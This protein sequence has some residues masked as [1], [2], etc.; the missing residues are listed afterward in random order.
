MR[1]RGADAGGPRK[2]SVAVAILCATTAVLVGLELRSRSSLTD[3]VAR[4]LPAPRD[5]EPR[6]A[7][8]R[9]PALESADLEKA[10]RASIRIRQALAGERSADALRASALL[11]LEPGFGQPA[12]ARAILR[13]EEAVGLDPDDASLWNDLAVAHMR[14]AKASDSP[15]DDL[16]ALELTQQA[17]R[18]DSLNPETRFNYALILERVFLLARAHDAFQ[19]V[20]RE[21]NSR[22]LREF[23]RT[24]LHFID[25]VRATPQWNLDEASLAA[26]SDSALR[27]LVHAVPQSAR[28]NL[29]GKLLPGW[30]ELTLQSGAAGAR[31]EL[32]IAQQ[33]AAHI[34]ER[35]TDHTF[36]EL[37]EAAARPQ[38][39]DSLR[40]LARGVLDYAEGRRLYVKALF[41]QA[42][43]FLSRAERELAAQ[44][45]AL[46]RLAGLEGAGVHMYA[47]RYE[48]AETILGNA[49]REVDPARFPVLVARA[50]YL[51]GLSQSR[52]GEQQSAIQEFQAAAALYSKLGERTNAALST[53][54]SAELLARLGYEEEAL[55]TWLRQLGELQRGGATTGLHDS[56]V[57]LGR[58]IGQ[59][60]LREAAITVHSEGLAVASQTGRPKD[61][62]EALLELARAELALNRTDSAALHIGLAR[63]HF[64]E[65][66]DP[67]MRDRAEANLAAAEGHL[68][69]S[70][71]PG[72][73]VTSL[74]TAVDHFRRQRNVINLARTLTLR[75]N[76]FENGGNLQRASVDLDSAI[77]VVVAEGISLKD[78][79]LRHSLLEAST[80]TFDN[81]IRI[82]VGRGR[83]DAAFHYLERSR[84]DFSLQPSRVD[85]SV[86]GGSALQ[87]VQRALA[88]ST[89]LIEYG[90]LSDR[91]LIWAITRDSVL[92]RAVATSRLTLAD[93]IDRFIRLI[94]QA[95]DKTALNSAASRL[96]DLLI[97]PVLPAIRSARELIIV[98]DM[99]LQ[100]LPFAALRSR[101]SAPYLVE[102]FALKT[103]ASAAALE[104]KRVQKRLGSTA[105]VLIVGE[106][107]LTP[108][109]QRTFPPLRFA[110]AEIEQV[111]TLYPSAARFSGSTATVTNV[112]GRLGDANILHF[113]GH[114]RYRADDPDASYL[115]LAADHSRDGFLHAA[116]LRTLRLPDLQLVILSA[117]STASRAESRIGGLSGLAGSFR[118]AGAYGVVGSLWEVDDAATR[119]LLVAFYS[120]LQ[121][122]GDP[123]RALREAQLELIRSG[124]AAL[125][126]PRSWSAFR[127]EGA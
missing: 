23:A 119:D 89:A 8:T 87:N 85:G 12:I 37:L 45:P 35:T 70:S 47:G 122:V 38:P 54:W 27:S 69:V 34:T 118:A 40:E 104:E 51:L 72:D 121:R 53:T 33:V 95:E 101:E 1:V 36:T 24:R 90:V 73:A 100:T 103:L 16:R 116:E 67:I 99:A 4:A 96:H 14:R 60:G 20:L 42:A 124:S 3:A 117:C 83:P 29:A 32:A 71:N 19:Y 126:D 105:R 48:T 125:A 91:L 108:E 93:E 10:E 102:Q 110:A 61:L 106:P 115:L 21:N 15:F 26:L 92:F 120:A 79:Q 50:H 97:A 44:A 84:R 113:A 112:L 39:A 28:E 65:L 58:A 7:L 57:T 56:L 107:S 94:Q 82:E 62:V 111:S 9:Q 41:A 109:L 49:L 76:A 123:A 2:R 80:N 46:A 98:P 77:D 5:G 30:A 18:L 55:R 114:A 88:D 13:L 11:D 86:A 6:F 74:N 52:R 66:T 63:P 78:P 68:R 64:P 75:A 127:Y 81:L 22:S 43:P 31:K 17:L 25:S 59:H